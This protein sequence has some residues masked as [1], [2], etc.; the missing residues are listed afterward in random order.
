MLDIEQQGEEAD[1]NP[2]IPGESL[3]PSLFFAFQAPETVVLL[4]YPLKHNSWDLFYQKYLFMRFFLNMH[5]IVSSLYVFQKHLN[6]GIGVMHAMP[7]YNLSL[8]W[9]SVFG[10]GSNTLI[11][12]RMMQYF[13]LTYISA[14]T[15]NDLKNLDDFAQSFK[16]HK[17]GM[18][19]L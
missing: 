19:F 2:A 5:D 3:L 6:A 11:T 1:K 10:R 9:I 15:Q 16:T 18:C 12:E 13:V 7:L 8:H 17:I 14:A 4:F